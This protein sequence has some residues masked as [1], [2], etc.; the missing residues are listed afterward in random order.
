MKNMKYLGLTLVSIVWLLLTVVLAISFIGIL[1]FIVHDG[2]NSYWF[3]YGRKLIDG[4]F[5][6]IE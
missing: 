1:V 5:L 4:F 2:K 6:K 3:S